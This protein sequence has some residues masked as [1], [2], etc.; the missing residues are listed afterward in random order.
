MKRVLFSCLATV[1]CRSLP[2]TSRVCAYGQATVCVDVCVYV[3]VYVGVY[4]C[5]YVCVCMYVCM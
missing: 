2:G 3:G 1:P 5:V 4:V